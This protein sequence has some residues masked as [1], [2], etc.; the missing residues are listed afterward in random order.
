MVLTFNS[1]WIQKGWFSAMFRSFCPG[2][3]DSKAFL[4]LFISINDRAKLIELFMPSYCSANQTLKS[5]ISHRFLLTIALLNIAS[6]SN[7]CFFRPFEFP[8][9]A[10]IL[11]IQKNHQLLVVW[12]EFQLSLLWFLCIWLWINVF[13]VSLPKQDIPKKSVYTR[14]LQKRYA[15]KLQFKFPS[16]VFLF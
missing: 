16:Q 10:L 11:F 5:S 6:L 2:L 4:I 12:F 7:L 3:V 9:S 8:A 1:S 15:N 13:S 14:T